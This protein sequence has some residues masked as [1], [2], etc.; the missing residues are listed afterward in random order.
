MLVQAIAGCSK[1]CKPELVEPISP[2]TT[3]RICEALPLLESI[4]WH[5]PRLEDACIDALVPLRSVK[6]IK[7]RS[8][9]GGSHTHLTRNQMT[10][11]LHGPNA[12]G[13]CKGGAW[14]VLE[15][16]LGWH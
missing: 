12:F 13:G 15:R 7:I 4:E 11:C 10:S 16:G 9:L 14:E 2:D 6:I 5:V 8:E 1:L 3:A